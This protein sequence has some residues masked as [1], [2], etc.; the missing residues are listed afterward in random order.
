MARRAVFSSF[1]SCAAREN[2]DELCFQF[3]IELDDVTTEKEMVRK[4]TGAEKV[5]A[6]EEEIYKIEIP[7]NR[8]DLLCVEGLSTALNIFRQVSKCP[9]YKLLEKPDAANDKLQTIRVDKSVSALR[10]VVVGCVLRNIKFT[11]ASYDSFIELQE[12][13]HQNICRKRTLVSI[14]T[15]DLDTVQGPFTYAAKSPKDI[16]FAPL[17][18][19]T[20]FDGVQL[21]Q[22]L[23]GHLQ[24][25][26]YLP[27]IR[28]SPVYPVITDAKGVVLSL[29]PIING[30]HSKITINTKNVLIEVTAVD[31]TKALVVLD[32]IAAAFSQHCATPFAV[33]PV[34]VVE[35]DGAI[36]V[37]PTWDRPHVCESKLSYLNGVCGLSL[38]ADEV[39]QLLA[40]MG[41]GPISQDSNGSDVTLHVTVP[42]TRSDVLH[43]CDLAEDLAIS[44]GFNK[45]PRILPKTVTAGKQLPLNKLTDSIRA[46]VAQHGYTEILSLIL[47]GREENFGHLNRADD[48]SAAI[49][50]N[51]IGTEFQIV[52]TTLLV[53][54]LKTLHSN[55]AMPLPLKLFEVSDV[56][57]QHANDVGARNRRMFSALFCDRDTAGFEKIH[58]LLDR[59]ML[60][61]DVVPELSGAVVPGK[62]S[63]RIAASEDPSFFPGRRADIFV[64]GKKVG[65]FGIVHPTVLKNFEI[66]NPVTAIEMSIEEFV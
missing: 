28:D 57:L 24:L 39:T 38:S 17:D 49:I 43:P 54:L 19:T 65:V 33:E 66:R 9:Q 16:K 56:V 8:Y 21:M 3:G 31:R 2:F 30:N 13:L 14:G 60:A 5:D 52:R 36:N 44:Y 37:A 29:P 55:K 58:G 48:G 61:L 11:D 42:P 26:K 35:A 63:Y 64:D 32:T 27:I 7:A 12:K 41:H 34:R 59:V 40:K 46:E 10:G 18:N 25:R 23:D 6:S 4:N 15:H 20:V 50:S 45:L 51:P 53:G 47:C 62:H 22:H 1:V